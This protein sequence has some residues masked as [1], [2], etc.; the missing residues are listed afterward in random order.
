[1]LFLI[2]E[3]LEQVFECNFMKLNGMTAYGRIYMY[4]ISLY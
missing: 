4:D 2:Y 3:Y 1:M